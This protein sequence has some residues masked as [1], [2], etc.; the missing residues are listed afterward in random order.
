MRAGVRAAAA[1][2]KA[3]LDR[4]GTALDAVVAAVRVLEDDPEFGA[5]LGSALTR[6]GTVETCASV[7]DG[8]RQKAGAVAAVQDLGQPVIVARAVLEIGE[9]V[10]LAGPAAQRYA[11]EIGMS[12]APAGSLVTQRS[13]AQHREAQQ[14][15]AT[16]L[17]NEGGGVGAVARDAKGGFASAT[18]TGGTI[19]RRA[20]CIDDSAVPGIG[21]WA[22]EECAVSTSGGEALFKVALHWRALAAPFFADDWLFLDMVRSRSLLGALLAHDPIGNY[23]RPLGRAVWFWLLAHASGE[24]PVVFHAANLALFLSCV[25]MLWLLARRVAGERAALAAAAVLALSYAADV[26]LR[27]A[28]GS[29]ELVA[30]TLA[31][32]A[33]LA[34]VS[35]RRAVATVLFLLAPLA[36]EIVAFAVI[37]AALLARQ[38]REPWRTT[39]LRAWPAL[40]AT[41]AW[42]AIAVTAAA[43]HQG[44]SPLSFSPLSP[45]AALAGPLRVLFGI[46]WS[47]GVRGNALGLAAQ[48]PDTLTPIAIVG[49]ALAALAVG[50]GW[51]ARARAASGARA[52]PG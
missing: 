16:R 23:F 38:P 50:L 49:V 1:A 45:L 46:E 13:M 28:S 32:G 20:G 27:W 36:K 9:H 10:M 42:A 12:P 41:A 47:T 39:A 26:P 17:A 48:A 43:R 5:G 4:G 31:L 3:L 11:A 25:V 15:G 35:G 21:S 6:E 8:A 24:S 33:M 19:Y 52:A 51:G 37:P 44:A 14:G 40:A 22:D 29:Q 2:G 30:V 7:M 18:S 34:F